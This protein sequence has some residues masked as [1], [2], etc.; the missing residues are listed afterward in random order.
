MS[1][2]F[3]YAVIGI[4]MEVH[5]ELGPG[6]DEA[7]YH[8]LLSRKLIAA[9][10]THLSR[11]RYPLVHCGITAD[12]YEPDLVFPG[13][14]VVELKCLTGAFDGEHYVQL[15]CYLKFLKIGVGLLFDFGKESLSYRR[16]QFSEPEFSVPDLATMLAACAALS[17]RPSAVQ[18][19]EA[20]QR[21]LRQHGLGY[22]DT[23]Y[24]GL[25]VAELSAGGVKCI[26][27]S[28]ADVRCGDTLLGQALCPCL[29]ANGQLAVGVLA[30]RNNISAAEIAILQTYLRLLD[31]PC[32]II[33]NFNKRA[34]EFCWVL[35]KDQN[36]LSALLP[37][38]CP[39]QS[40]GNENVR[41]AP[42][43][44]D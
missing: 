32:G 36:I 20:T 35:R 2:Q 3:T 21:I 44:K 28:L 1:D 11:P 34:V 10:V 7:F 40:L 19:C 23:T 30:L 17:A 27:N 37:H 31:L 5:R 9:G 14:L 4:A 22:R 26:S 15:I 38:L 6:L 33:L 18:V 29:V 25:L 13:H 16:V 39:P 42:V 24:F 12:L 8:E 43:P 41:T